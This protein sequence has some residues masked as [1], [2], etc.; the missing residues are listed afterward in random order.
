MPS[1]LRQFAEIPTYSDPG[2]QGQTCRD[3]L[4]CGIV[5]DLLVGYNILEGPARVGLGNHPAWH[6]VFVVVQGRGMLLWDDERLPVQAPCV[7]HIPPG[8]DHDVSV[9]PGQRV[10]YVYINRY[11]PASEGGGPE[12]QEANLDEQRQT[13]D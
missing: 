2:S 8:T 10:E 1:Y 9:E 3:I 13:E 4:P 6:Q 12:N 5:P 11:L 7:V